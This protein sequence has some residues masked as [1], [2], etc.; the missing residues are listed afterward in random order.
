[1]GTRNDKNLDEVSGV[2]RITTYKVRRSES[3]IKQTAT[4]HGVDRKQT[5]RGCFCFLYTKG[6]K[7]ISD[8]CR[9]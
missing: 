3:T 7:E 1:M 2:F 8:L 4:Y 9:L 5:A 6:E